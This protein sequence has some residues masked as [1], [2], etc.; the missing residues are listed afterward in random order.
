MKGKTNEKGKGFTT[1]V[2]DNLR[3]YVIFAFFFY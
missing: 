2:F 3:L 1:E